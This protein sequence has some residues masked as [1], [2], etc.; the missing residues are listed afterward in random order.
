LLL[1]FI[2]VV[3]QFA[4]H[5]L[6]PTKPY[7]GAVAHLWQFLI[8]IQLPIIA[9]FGFRWLRRAPWQAATVLA[10]QGLALAAAAVIPVFVFG[11]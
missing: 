9:V 5:P 7:E 11:W 8:A 2:Q 6:E 10:V 4:T 1:V 3:L